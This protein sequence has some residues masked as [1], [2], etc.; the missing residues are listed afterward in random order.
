MGGFLR[1]VRVDG[2]LRTEH[3][4]YGFVEHLFQTFLSE[5]RTFQVFYCTD[6]LRHLEALCNADR[7]QFLFF[8]LLDSLLVVSQIQLGSH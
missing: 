4:S 2:F 3:R 5:C 6:L 1:V 8:Q 7:L